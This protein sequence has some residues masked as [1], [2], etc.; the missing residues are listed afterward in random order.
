MPFTLSHPVA[1]LPF[2]KRLPP[3]AL[4]VGAM[5]PDLPYYAPLPFSPT[6]THSWLGTVLVDLPV[7]LVVLALF[8]F[9]LRPPLTALAPQGL[10]AR[11]PDRAPS[12][13]ALL[14]TAALLTGAATHL[15]WD[16]FTHVDGFFVLHWPVM[17][18]SVVGVHR[19]FNVVM[20]VSSLGG[21]AVL[22]GWFAAWYRR[23]PV[24]PGRLPGVTARLRGLTLLACAT[25][26]TVEALV[27]GTGDGAAASLY[28]LVRAVLLGAMI[29]CTTVLTCY[30]IAW[31]LRPA[32]RRRPG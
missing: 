32:L 21:L 30:A 10:R 17:R 24:R 18:T 27:F 2:R 13:R 3:A 1:I 28:D 20:Y 6:F 29:G 8:H 9:V 14:V 22:A 4:A 25:A 11:L 5:V 7:G 12:Q 31:H 23:A 15:V 19:V 16:S 26:A